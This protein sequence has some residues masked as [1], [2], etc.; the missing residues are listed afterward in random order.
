MPAPRKP[1]T[2]S[3]APVVGWVL[4]GATVAALLLYLALGAW[5][6]LSLAPGATGILVPLIGA[7]ALAGLGFQVWARNQLEDSRLFPK[8][9]LA[10]QNLVRREGVAPVPPGE[11]PAS[12]EA[13]SVSTLLELRIALQVI[14]WAVSDA[15][16]CLGLLLT[17]LTGAHAYLLGFAAVAA[18]ALLLD[19]PRGGKAREQAGRWERYLAGR[20]YGGPPV[21]PPPSD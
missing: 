16:A 18:A 11:E 8:V 9:L 6:D 17:L 7:L 20:T 15:V 2:P 5:L 21:A 19:A 4:W 14:L 12:F 10:W 3:N 13:R 1:L